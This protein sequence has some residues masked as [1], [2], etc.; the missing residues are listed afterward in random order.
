MYFSHYPSIFP[1]LLACLPPS[2]SVAIKVSTHAFAS[3]SPITLAP[4]AIIFASLCSLESLAVNSLYAR[5]ALIPST[6]LAEI[7][8][9]I[10][11]PQISIPYCAFPSST[12][13]LT[14]LAISG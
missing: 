11:V 5:A 8:I 4:N 2:N 10:P 1:T 12:T 7:D 6:L 14:F 3:S 9:P 13:S